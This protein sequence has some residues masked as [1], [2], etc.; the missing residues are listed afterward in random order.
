MIIKAKKSLGQNFLK[1]KKKSEKIVNYVDIISTDFVVEIGPG[2]GNLTEILL[3]KAKKVFVIEK[4]NRLI[5]F[6]EKKFLKYIKNKKLE[7]IE[8]DVLDFNF[9]DYFKNKK[10]KVVAN[11][12]YYITGKFISNILEKEKNQPTI[13]VLL[14]QKEVVERIAGKKKIQKNNIL[15]ISIDIYGKVKQGFTVGKKNFS[16]IP[17]VDSAVLIV[18]DIS[19]FFFIKNNILEKDFF[20]F[21]KLAFAQ[22]RKQVINNL[23]KSFCEK[24]LKKIFIKLNLPLNIRAEDLSLKDFKNIFI[25]LF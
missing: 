20:K 10:Y 13:L 5:P 3:K 11:L 9:S 8:A 16:P 22:K 7:I 21:I 6:L 15:K 23:K 25:N 1:D 14:L 19:K 2:K 17:K 24:K 4:D 18:Y 12:P